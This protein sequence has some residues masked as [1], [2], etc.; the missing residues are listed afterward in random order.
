VLAVKAL[1]FKTAILPLERLAEAMIFQR[2]TLVY[3]G[4]SDDPRRSEKDG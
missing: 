2:F 3:V 1:F 4:K